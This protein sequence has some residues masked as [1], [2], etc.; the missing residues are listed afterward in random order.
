MTKHGSAFGL[1]KK[2]EVDNRKRPTAE[3]LEAT[4]KLI[5]ELAAKH[6][7]DPYKRRH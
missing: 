4:E 3:E 7:V 2:G 6:G 5:A 1:K